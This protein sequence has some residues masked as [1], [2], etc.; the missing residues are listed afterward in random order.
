MFEWLKRFFQSGSFAPPAF[1]VDDWG[2]RRGDD[3]KVAWD[4]LVGVDIVTTDEGPYAEDVFFVLHGKDGKGCVVPQEVAAARSLLERLQRL[5]GFDNGRLIE[6]MGCAENARFV[7][8]K[9]PA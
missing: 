6:A 1:F 4:D 3:E 7:C 9:K 2:V 8:W 5:P